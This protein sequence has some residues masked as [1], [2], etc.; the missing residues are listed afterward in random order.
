[1]GGRDGGRIET[2]KNGVKKNT[3]FIGMGMTRAFQN[4]DRNL[5]LRESVD[6]PLLTVLREFLFER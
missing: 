3:N 1:M 4:S 6:R 2:E 5:I